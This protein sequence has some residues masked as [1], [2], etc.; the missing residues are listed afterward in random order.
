[1]NLSRATCRQL[2]AMDLVEGIVDALRQVNRSDA[3]MDQVLRRVVRLQG[4][5]RAA[6]VE[7]N[8]EGGYQFDTHKQWRRY[9]RIISQARD[10]FLALWP[11]EDLD[12]REYVNAVLLYLDELWLQARGTRDALGRLIAELGR[13]YEMMDPELA[14]DEQM[15]VGQMAGERLTN[16]M[17]AQA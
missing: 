15:E 3:G 2:L 7:I 9:Q 17:E 4:E 13:V 8:A 6:L 14:A 1:M 12:G 10:E 16:M 5:I 11:G